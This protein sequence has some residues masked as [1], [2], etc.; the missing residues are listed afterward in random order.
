MSDPR[1]DLLVRYAGAFAPDVVARASGSFIETTDGRRLL[2]FTAG[3]VCATVGHNHPRVVAAIEEACRTVLHLNSWMLSE[4]LLT[5][6]ER[7]LA[8]VPAPLERAMFLSTGGEAVEA[9]LR[10]AKLHTGNFE[11]V[12]L[13]RG[14]HGMTAGAS[15]I[16]LSAGRRGLGP[17]SP[18]TLA[19]PAP[20][21]Y[22][23]PIRHCAGTCDCTCL[24]AGFDMV[25]QMS[26]GSL[27]AVVVEPVLSAGGV[28]VPPAE[29]FARLLDLAR[30][31]EMLVIFDESQTGLGRL[32]TMYG[33]EL[34]DTLPDF[35]VLSKTLGGGVPISALVTSAEIEQ[36]CF[37]R[38]FINVTSHVSDPLPAAAANAVL[39]V[40]L[41]EGLVERA[42]RR[43]DYLLA[44]LDQLQGR[45][46]CV[47][48]VRGVGLLCGIELVEDR[49]TKRPAGDLGAA[50]TDACQ[51]CG[52]SVNAVRGRADG[53]ANCIRMA[54]PLTVTEDEI[55]RAV[56]IMDEA[57]VQVT[58]GDLMPPRT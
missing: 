46:E 48:D 56:S 45:H 50:F 15:S 25:D 57:L 3:Q 26:V 29:Y 55:D 35:L 54:P 10:M 13:T 52:L 28:I 7:L 42:G 32:G 22:R 43:G 23:C 49:E 53:S 51:R 58:H 40:V 8:T 33:F 4:Q 17:A 6:A 12:A 16:T 36:S 44:Q 21:G 34:Y 9:A 37:E 38:N 31:R 2:D 24:E 19:I 27:A 41:D 18:G 1:S 11:V 5:L 14:W 20:Y 30:E 39:D 47:G